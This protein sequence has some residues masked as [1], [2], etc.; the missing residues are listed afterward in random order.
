[1]GED[2]PEL[3]Q[4][5]RQ[6]EGRAQREG[7][8]HRGLEVGELA[9]TG[10]PADEQEGSRQCSKI[11]GREHQGEGQ[12]SEGGETIDP[13]EDAMDARTAAFT[14]SL[15]TQSASFFSAANPRGRKPM[16]RSTPKKTAMARGRTHPQCA[17]G[18]T[19]STAAQTMSST[20]SKGCRCGRGKREVG[21]PGPL[22][23]IVLDVLARRDREPLP[24][25]GS[26][27]T[28]S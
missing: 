3:R 6:E 23:A 17:M 11:S 5:P 27:P 21:H 4:N 18:N 10:A 15:C 16:N 2:E 7:V 1:M 14:R 20:R 12:G 22:Q 24:P 25:D 8:D 19:A 26:S 28:A 13:V 9:D